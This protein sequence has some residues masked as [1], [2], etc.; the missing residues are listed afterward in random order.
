[1]F[2]YW[3]DFRPEGQVGGEVAIGSAVGSF[4]DFS[5]EGENGDEVVANNRVQE[6]RVVQMDMGSSFTILADDP[7]RPAGDDSGATCTMSG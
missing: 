2:A 1:M 6:L 3:F 5:A 4:L 7:D